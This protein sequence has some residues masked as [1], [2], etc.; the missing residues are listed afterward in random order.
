MLWVCLFI[1]LAQY[2]LDLPAN[3]SHIWKKALGGTFLQQLCTTY[4]SAATRSRS[5]SPPEKPTRSACCGAAVEERQPPSPSARSHRV[6]KGHL[7]IADSS[8]SWRAGERDPGLAPG[9]GAKFR[10]STITSEP[11]YS[12]YTQL[13]P[14][15]FSSFVWKEIIVRRL[16]VSQTLGRKF[17]KKK[18]HS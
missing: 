18:V 10:F 9:L 17:T 16:L 4:G 15:G 3:F 7:L 13:E 11:K 12:K 6:A 14:L 5:A 2:V 1:P 8:R